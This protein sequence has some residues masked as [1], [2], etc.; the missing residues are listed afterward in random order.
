MQQKSVNQLEKDTIP[1]FLFFLFGSAR[2][3][4]KGINSLQSVPNDQ[5]S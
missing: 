1:D 5:R 4:R 2:S 3:D